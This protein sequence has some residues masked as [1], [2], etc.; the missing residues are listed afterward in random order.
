MSLSGPDFVRATQLFTLFSAVL[1]ALCVFARARRL[2]RLHHQALAVNQRL[3][4]LV[5]LLLQLGCQPRV[6]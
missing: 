4:F 1:C 2:K 5:Q 6:H 3:K